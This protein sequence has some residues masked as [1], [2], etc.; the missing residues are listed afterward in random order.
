MLF[1]LFTIFL[2]FF[3]IV[4]TLDQIFSFDISFRGRSYAMLFF[5]CP[6]ND[7]EF[8]RKSIGLV[9]IR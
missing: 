3:L 6:C 5:E 4:E 1:S 9:V 7:D 2:F 8:L